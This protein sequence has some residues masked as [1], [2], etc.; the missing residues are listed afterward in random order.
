MSES[1]NKDFEGVKRLFTASIIFLL[2]ASLFYYIG[3]INTVRLSYGK[4][5]NE[6]MEFYS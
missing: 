3:G 4:I 1:E 6:Q 2:V 5:V